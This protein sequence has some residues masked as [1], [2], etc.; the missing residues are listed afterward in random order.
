VPHAAKPSGEGTRIGIDA[1]EDE[2]G[3]KRI[4]L[5]AQCFWTAQPCSIPYGHAGLMLDQLY[6]KGS[7]HLSPIVHFMLSNLLVRSAKFF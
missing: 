1:F 6:S 4:A 3:G 7:V 2:N 5:H